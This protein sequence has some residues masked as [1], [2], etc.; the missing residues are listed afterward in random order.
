M[1]KSPE[2]FTRTNKARPYVVF[3]MH[4]SGT[5]MITN[6]L[7]RCGVFMGRDLEKNR[8]SL[9]F[10]KYNILMLR[11]LGAGWDV[12]GGA[13]ILASDV[14]VLER[15]SAAAAGVFG[16]IPRVKY[17]GMN[18]LFRP[19]IFLNRKWG[20]KDPRNTLTL[21]V[22]K[23][24]FPRAKYIYMIRDGRDVAGSLVKRNKKNLKK[25]PGGRL[26]RVIP[27]LPSNLGLLENK[28][29]SRCSSL[30]G[31]FKLW[32][33]YCGIAEYFLERLDLDLLRVRYE[34]VLNGSPKTRRDILDF[35]GL[36]ADPSYAFG[37]IRFPSEKGGE[38][39][40]KDNK[41]DAACVK[42]S[43]FMKEYGYLR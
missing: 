29:S 32:E 30:T 41:V 11:F 39:S 34:D 7:Q 27:F 43:R 21:P 36:N 28:Y 8:E 23:K 42:K 38:N 26:Y 25:I 5:S 15:L 24:L 4:R 17:F 20:W 16:L 18:A 22:W 40:K 31:A 10:L 9:T 14:P 6:V 1:K 3:G 19:D 33:E 13:K 12:P 2:Y 37:N 35:I